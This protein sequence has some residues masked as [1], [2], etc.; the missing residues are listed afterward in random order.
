MSKTAQMVGVIGI[1]VVLL[2]IVSFFVTTWL[3]MILAGMIG[4]FANNEW[5]KSLSYWQCAPVWVMIVILK[6]LFGSSKS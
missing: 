2:I 4:H 6:L 5:L 3:V 1:A